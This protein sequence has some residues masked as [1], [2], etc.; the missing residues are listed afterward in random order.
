MS[1]LNGLI[2]EKINELFVGTN[3][4][5]RYI[6]FGLSQKIS[7]NC[8]V[9]EEFENVGKPTLS[10]TTEIGICESLRKFHRTVR[11]RKNLKIFQNWLDQLPRRL[12]VAKDS[13]NFMKPRDIGKNMKILEN[14]L[15][16]HR[17]GEKLT[18]DSE[19][20]IELRGRERI[21]KCWTTDSIGYDGDCSCRRD[22]WRIFRRRGF[23]IGEIL[24]EKSVKILQE[25]HFE[26][27]LSLRQWLRLSYSS[28]KS[29]QAFLH[30]QAYTIKLSS[31]HQVYWR[32]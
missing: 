18:R 16:Q 7:S 8:E 29:W 27:V 3:E 30:S 22:S 32:T 31:M 4:T 2:L 24:T 1:V 11:Y 23:W 15:Y 17:R 14:L 12:L 26:T 21:W 9:E 13:E 5:V 20:F 19:N 28:Y 6:W 25:K 10:A